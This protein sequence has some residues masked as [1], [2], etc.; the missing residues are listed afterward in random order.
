MHACPCKL[1]IKELLALGAWPTGPAPLATHRPRGSRQQ[2]GP[3]TSGWRLELPRGEQNR[4]SLL[5]TKGG[6]A[7]TCEWCVTEQPRC[8]VASFSAL[9]VGGLS[10]GIFNSRW[11]EMTSFVQPQP[12][13]CT[14]G[15]ARRSTVSIPACCLSCAPCPWSL[16]TQPHQMP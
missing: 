1:R 8:P 4:S 3:A 12:R 11:L 10:L 5:G 2:V 15:V 9:R 6:S 13:S 16:V 14:A 7:G